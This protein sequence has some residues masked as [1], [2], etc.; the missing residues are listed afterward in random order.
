MD[1]YLLVAMV[2][3]AG[4]AIAL[5]SITNS[6]MGQITGVL[7]S[8]FISFGVGTLVA[9]LLLVFGVGR[10]DLAA[11]TGAPWYLFIGG[12]AGPVMC[13]CDYPEHGNSRGYCRHGRRNS[14]PAYW[15]SHSGSFR[16]SRGSSNFFRHLARIGDSAAPSRCAAD[17]TLEMKQ[18]PE[19]R[20]PLW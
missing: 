9:A 15:W 16:G 10:G 18:A 13:L 11:A 7:E 8:S 4:A 14:R 5:Q 17:H 6:K 19:N 20:R 12:A 3:V 2:A 1:K